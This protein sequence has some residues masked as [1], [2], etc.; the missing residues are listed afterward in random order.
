L[1][2]IREPS[3]LQS[4]SAVHATHVPPLQIGLLESVQSLLS[5][6]PE[7]FAQQVPW[8]APVGILQEYPPQ[9]PASFTHVAPPQF[10]Q[11]L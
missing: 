9:H 11:T 6:Q 8:D 2:Q 10:G 3:E 7:L 1:E 5:W 4:L